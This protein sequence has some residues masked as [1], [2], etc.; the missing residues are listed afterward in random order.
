M[1]Y[2]ISNSFNTNGSHQEDVKVFNTNGSDLEELT[3][4]NTNGSHIEDVKFRASYPPINTPFIW[5]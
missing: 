2:I 5:N 1:I 4:F 3:V